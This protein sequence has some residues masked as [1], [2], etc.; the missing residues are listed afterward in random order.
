MA[1]IMIKKTSFL[2]LG[3]WRETQILK[4]N[5]THSV[6]NANLI[7]NCLSFHISLVVVINCGAGNAL[8][9]FEISMF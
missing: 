8:G 1:P 3:E 2:V 6:S 7:A 4:F 9:D 5:S